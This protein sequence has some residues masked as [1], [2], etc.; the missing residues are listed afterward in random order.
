MSKDRYTIAL[1]HVSMHDE[2]E[3]IVGDMASK[4]KKYCPGFRRI[5]TIWERHFHHNQGL[6]YDRRDTDW[7]KRVDYLALAVETEYFNHPLI[8]D[9]QRYTGKVTE[10]QLDIMQRI[11]YVEDPETFYY[12]NIKPAK[13]AA[14]KLFAA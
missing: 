7:I 2:H 14:K 6:P 10:W 11:L 1:A 12:Q 9:P 4:L 3:M 8:D 5:E 13:T